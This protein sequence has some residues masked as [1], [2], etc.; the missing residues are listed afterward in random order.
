MP[1][2]SDVNVFAWMKASPWRMVLPTCATLFILTGCHAHRQVTLAIIPRTTGT[3]LWEPLQGGAETEARR[4]GYRLYGNAPAREDDVEKQ[5]SLV[6][7]VTRHHVQGIILAPSQSLALITPVRRALAVGIP[8]VVVSSPLAMPPSGRLAYVINDEERAGVICGERIGK[9]TGGS[10]VVIV[11][12]VNPDIA[13]ILTRMR[14]LESYLARVYPKIIVVNRYGTLNP[15]HEQ[16][17]AQEAI[18]QN[19][20]AKAIVGLMWSSTH[21]ALLAVRDREAGHSI[22]VIG[23]DPDDVPPMDN[24]DLDSVLV[25]NTRLMGEQAV[26]LLAGELHGSAMPPLTKIAPVLITRENRNSLEVQQVLWPSSG[27]Y[28]WERP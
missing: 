23:F 3:A 19:P 7:Q 11:L 13:G 17:V 16:Q 22:R 20:T 21:G 28:S 1:T 4:Y 27:P 14:S 26:A 18:A 15:I 9:L 8:A 25:Q 12:G 2:G 5:I 10:G 24:P 6:E